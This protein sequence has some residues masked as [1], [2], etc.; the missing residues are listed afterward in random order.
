[1]RGVAPGRRARR[2]GHDELHFAGH[3]QRQLN[4]SLNTGS[5]SWR[6]TH[7]HVGDR[8]RPW[9]LI[10]SLIT[11]TS[12]AASDRSNR[13]ATLVS[14]RARL[15]RG[16][17]AGLAQPFT[18]SHGGTRGGHAVGCGRSS[19]RWCE[20]ALVQL[21]LRLRLWHEQGRQLTSRGL[22]A[23]RRVRTTAGERRAHRALVGRR[24]YAWHITRD[25]NGGPTGLNPA[26]YPTS[27]WRCQ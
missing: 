7:G 25:A 8:S 6:H 14:S 1:M 17:V 22:S 24:G 3:T 20:R 4:N 5:T 9:Q 18:A 12:V 23:E 10:T 16:P 21:G 19:L 26:V 27:T 15:S 2:Q 11:S 13:D